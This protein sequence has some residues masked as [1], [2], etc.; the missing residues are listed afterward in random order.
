[1][2]RLRSG[3]WQNEDPSG[4][5]GLAYSKVAAEDH[6]VV[7]DVQDQTKIRYQ[8]SLVALIQSQG[9]WRY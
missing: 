7:P 9:G 2:L 1:M 3:P 8:G 4:R 5:K 6:D